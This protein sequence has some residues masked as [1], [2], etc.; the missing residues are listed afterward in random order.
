MDLRR[1]AVFGDCEMIGIGCDMGAILILGLKF[2]ESL[3]QQLDYNY[4]AIDWRATF[5]TKLL[6][7]RFQE[8]RL[9]RLPNQEPVISIHE[10][11]GDDQA[12]MILVGQLSGLITILNYKTKDLILTV[13]VTDYTKS[14]ANPRPNLLYHLS[15]YG[16]FH[17]EDNPI[18]I[19]RDYLHGVYI[20]NLKQRREATIVRARRK[21]QKWRVIGDK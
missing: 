2:D 21:K 12:G 7:E 14:Q 19:V 3:A 4:K 8:F 17:I 1:E 18:V 11:K 5:N 20:V 15:P 16:N 10:F 9:I 13:N 6:Y